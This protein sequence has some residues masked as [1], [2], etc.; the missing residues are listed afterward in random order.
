[1]QVSHAVGKHAHACSCLLPNPDG[2]TVKLSSSWP[3]PATLL[4]FNFSDLVPKQAEARF[5]DIARLSALQLE[6]SAG[7]VTPVMAAST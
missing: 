6:V 7:S 1:M 2:V 4:Q 3:L 5:G